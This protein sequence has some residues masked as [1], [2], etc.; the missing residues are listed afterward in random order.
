MMAAKPRK[1]SW[2]HGRSLKDKQA[3]NGRTLALNGKAWRVLRE[4]VLAGEPCC[5]HCVARGLTVAA[6]DVDHWDNDS[7]NNELVNLVPLCHECHSRKT[8]KDMGRNVA[9]G[10]GVDGV[11]LDPCHPWNKAARAALVRPAGTVVEKSPAADSCE[12]TVYLQ[13]N[14]NCKDKP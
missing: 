9:M 8:A 1:P 11:P 6:T 14:A 10:C 4:S 5:R 2:L 12:P 3:S 13:F 7:T